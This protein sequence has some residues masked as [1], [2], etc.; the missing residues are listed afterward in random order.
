M[1]EI[2][3]EDLIAE[4]AELLGGNV[5]KLS[6]DRLLHLITITQHATNVLLNEIE[7][8]DRLTF[9]EEGI[10]VLPYVSDYRLETILTRAKDDEPGDL[11]PFSL[12][13]SW[14]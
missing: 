11:A 2:S 10:P 12:A 1:S 5:A 8:R 3:K 6:L 9:N 13:K 4:T 14:H 7:R